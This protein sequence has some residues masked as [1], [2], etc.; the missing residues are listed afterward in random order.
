M[1][2]GSGLLSDAVWVLLVPPV[3]TALWY[4]LARAWTGLLG[5]ANRPRVRGWT[6]SGIWIIMGGLYVIGIA[7]FIYAHVIKS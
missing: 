1:T 4:L 5:T 6:R 2:K 3:M 7:F